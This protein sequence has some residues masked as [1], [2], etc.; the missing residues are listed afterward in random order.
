MLHWS[1]Y[2]QR[3]KAS[4]ASK[5]PFD[6]QTSLNASICGVQ[7]LKTLSAKMTLSQWKLRLLKLTT[8]TP[9]L[10]RQSKHASDPLTPAAFEL[11]PAQKKALSKHV[12]VPVW[13]KFRGASGKS[14][15][16]ERIK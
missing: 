15:A 16:I 5:D 2:E 6:Q 4:Q 3:Y 11:Q 8:V 13:Y 10:Q 7:T 14:T 9:A 12:P 1:G